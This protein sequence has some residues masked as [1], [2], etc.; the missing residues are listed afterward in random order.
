MENFRANVFQMLNQILQNLAVQ[1]TAGY[2]QQNS[3][4]SGAF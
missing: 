3:S 2:S 1:W 4:I